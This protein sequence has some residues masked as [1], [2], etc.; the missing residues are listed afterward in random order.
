MP[1]LQVGVFRLVSI[2]WPTPS[3]QSSAF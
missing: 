1:I 2:F 3:N